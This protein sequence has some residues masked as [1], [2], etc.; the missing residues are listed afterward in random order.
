MIIG[1]IFDNVF[2][3]L[4]SDDTKKIDKKLN[5]G[6]EITV[7]SLSSKR[8]FDKGSNG[9]YIDDDATVDMDEYSGATEAKLKSTAIEQ[10]KYDP[11]T[12]ECW[13][14]FVDNPKWY[15]FDNMSE[16]QFKTFMNAS[17]KG[18]YVNNVMK[19]KNRSKG[20]V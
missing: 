1:K 5:K 17:S 15:K 19:V 8:Y 16:Q 20:Y 6:K 13:I 14:Q 9:H 7:T 12:K 18:R 3:N 2:K 11:K 4:T 10:A